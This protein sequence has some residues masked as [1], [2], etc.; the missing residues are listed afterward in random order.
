MRIAD[1]NEQRKKTVKIQPMSV[2]FQT[3]L[4]L[5]VSLSLFRLVAVIP[6]I[7]INTRDRENVNQKAWLKTG[8]V[9]IKNAPTN[10]GTPTA[11]G[12]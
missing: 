9:F 12:A 8:V 6:T 10:T 2:C 5:P 7:P 1:K 11:I 3:Q 4:R